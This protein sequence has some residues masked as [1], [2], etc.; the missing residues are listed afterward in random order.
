M[1]KAVVRDKTRANVYIP[2]AVSLLLRI[3]INNKGY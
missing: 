2:K 3:M 1:G